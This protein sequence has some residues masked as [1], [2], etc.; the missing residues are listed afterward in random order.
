MRERFHMRTRLILS[1][2]VAA[3][4]PA[5]AGRSPALHPSPGF[6]ERQ[7]PASAGG[8]AEWERYSRAL[9]TGIRVR[10][11]LLDG[12]RFT[13]TL[14]GVEGRD[15]VLQRATRIPERPRRIPADEVAALARDEG[16]ISAGKAALI[17]LGVG[18]G[19]FLALLLVAFALVGD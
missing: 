5:C 18:A 3:S 19:S 16:G 15:I 17:G 6:D 7:L 11:V 1:I 8:G 13:A 9:P 10:V 12:T 2:L 14:L 4:V